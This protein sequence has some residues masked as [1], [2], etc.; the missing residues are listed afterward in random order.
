MRNPSTTAAAGERTGLTWPSIVRLGLVQVAI[1]AV[2]VLMTSTLNRV[3]VVELGLIAAVPGALVG[4]HFA[5]QLLRPR[6]GFGSDAGRRRIPWIVGGMA[7]VAV[8]GVGAAAATALMSTHTTLGLT[9]AVVAFMS[10][11]VGVSASSTPLLAYLAEG[12]ERSRMAGAAAVF[13]IMMI[14]GII[15]TAG[16]AGSFLDPFTPARLVAVCAV[17][18]S[19]A[20]VLTLVAVI[21]RDEERDRAVH[22]RFRGH[23]GGSTSFKETMLA[24]WREP[25]ARAFA[26]FVFISMLAYSAQDI[27][28]EPFAGAVFGMTPGES[29]QIAG[30]QHGGVLL[31]MGI[32]AVG[33][34]R[35]GTL[36]GWSAAGCLASAVSLLF[37]VITPA[38]GAG[39]LTG[40]VF[41]LG[42]S[43]GVFAV[44]AIGAMM[45]LTVEGESGG[46]GLRMGFW[47]AAQ[48]MAY[49][50]GGFLGAAAS[51]VA[52]E[53]SGSAALGYGTVFAAEAVL[54]V[55]AAGI[56][57]GA[58]APT[59]A[60][61]MAPLRQAAEAAV[62]S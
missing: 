51:D 48:A 37:I 61:G 40:G 35:V 19:V 46:A 12:V 24:M 18:C 49:G 23:E 57:L 17:V 43:N 50:A 56:M 59:R 44:A 33:A 31:G 42:L 54:F 5:V 26:S 21:G 28:L 60:R 20:M 8:S 34:A 10:L 38:L 55:V 2:V 29:T 11:G 15:L 58:V 7:L 27:I 53:V 52:R 13:W 45:G 25:Q 62:T 39:A 30:I 4:L 3:M 32:G 9:V 36:R 14:A 47:G 1:G 16:V 6:M 41:A 22:E